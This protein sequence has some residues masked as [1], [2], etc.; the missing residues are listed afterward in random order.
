LVKRQSRSVN[1]YIPRVF[2][3]IAS[4]EAEPVFNVD[5]IVSV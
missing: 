5:F 1:G 4:I 3:R 2:A